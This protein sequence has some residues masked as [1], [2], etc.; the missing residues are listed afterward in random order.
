M[1][2]MRHLRMQARLPS[3]QA[4]P[5]S[6]RSVLCREVQAPGAGPGC[7]GASEVLQQ[8]GGGGQRL[9]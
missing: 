8:C 5:N 9:S 7:S 1:G 3:K 6:L 2:N 4:H